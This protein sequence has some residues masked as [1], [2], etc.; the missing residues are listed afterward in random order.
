MDDK[1]KAT[2]EKVVRLTQQ[3]AEFGAELRKALGMEPSANFA[4]KDINRI[5]NI[6]KY[7]GLDYYVDT[8]RSVVDYSFVTHPDVR[9]QLI[10]DNREMM[11]Y[12]YG[13]RYHAID[14]NEF[15]RYAQ[16][17]SEMLINYYYDQ[18]NNSDFQR[19]VKHIHKYNSKASFDYSSS[20]SS[21]PYSVKLWAFQKEFDSIKFRETWENVRI[22]RNELSHR[23]P[24]VIA[25]NVERYKAYLISLGIAVSKRGF[26]LWNSLAQQQKDILVNLQKTEEYKKYIF[27]VWCHHQPYDEIIESLMTISKLVKQSVQ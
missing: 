23:S 20:L 21:I 6:E 25:L 5:Q 26:V 14:F 22:V 13:T 11:R 19:I 10:S 15:C 24:E 17:Q 3:N 8:Q 2:L 4:S 27:D 18:I 7:L 16:L 12:R 1:L 9:A